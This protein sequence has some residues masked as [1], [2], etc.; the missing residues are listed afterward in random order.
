MEE[1]DGI[2]LGFFHP[3]FRECALDSKEKSTYTLMRC[4]QPSKSPLQDQAIRGHQLGSKDLLTPTSC[5]LS[6]MK[7]E[8]DY[9]IK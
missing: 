8:M 1:K 2:A 4:F 6:K 9:G 3:L 5:K 7:R